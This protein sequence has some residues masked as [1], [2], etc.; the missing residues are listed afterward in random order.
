MGIILAANAMADNIDAAWM[1][2][3]NYIAFSREGTFPAGAARVIAQT[4]TFDHCNFSVSPGAP[5][6]L[7]D[8]FTRLLLS[9]S[10]QDSVVRPLFELEGLK[11]WRPGRCTGY[12][13]LERAVDNEGFCDAEGNILV[14]DYR[15]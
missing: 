9:M 5:E 6:E 10:W 2:D 13:L 11:E 3:G 14:G 8:T 15:F 4:G 12:A 7:I 1:T